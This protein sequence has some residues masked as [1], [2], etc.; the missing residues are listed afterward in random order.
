MKKMK[1]PTV[2]TTQFLKDV[3][4]KS[5]SYE[6]ENSESKFLPMD[7]IEDYWGKKE[8]RK[9]NTYLTQND[10]KRVKEKLLR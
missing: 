10:L 9:R 7:L 3:A 2:I 4:S 5:L 6:I 1:Q 8:L